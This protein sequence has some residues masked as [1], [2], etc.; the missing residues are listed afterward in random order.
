MSDLVK[1]FFNLSGYE[2]ISVDSRFNDIVSDFSSQSIALFL[3][4]NRENFSIFKSNKTFQDIIKEINLDVKNLDDLSVIINAIF[5]VK[6]I[7]HLN[8]LKTHFLRLNAAEIINDSYTRSLCELFNKQKNE[9]KVIKEIKLSGL[10]VE[11]NECYKNIIKIGIKDKTKQKLDSILQNIESKKFSIGV[12]GVMSAGKSTF[13]NALLGDEILGTST[14]P[15]T[16]NLTI[17]KHAQNKDDE[18]A[19]VY[20]WDKNEWEELKNIGKFDKKIESFIQE[21]EEKFKE[22]L[23]SILDSGFKEIEL[24]D[25]SE[26]TS[27]NTESKYC[28]L[29]KKV[30]LF[31]PLK[32]LENGVS[33]VDTPGLDDPVIKREEITKEYIKNC[34][35]LIHVMNA[36]CAATKVDI[37]FIT[38]SFLRH[39]IARMLVILTR[40]DLV[41]S[42]S[43]NA[44]MNYTKSEIINELKKA[45]FEGDVDS[46][47]D[48]IE[49]ISLAGYFA[50]LHKTNRA[51][52]ALDSGYTLEKTGI[53]EIENYLYKTLLG[54]DSAKN[55]DLLLIAFRGF[56]NEINSQINDLKLES[57]FLNADKTQLENLINDIKNENIELEKSLENIKIKN[58]ESKQNLEK[59]LE[60][61]SK[62]TANGIN[63]SISR[64]KDQIYNDCIYEYNKNSAPSSERI[65]QLVNIN[66]D[67]ISADILRDYK[68]KII[69]FSSTFLESNNLDFK[70]NTLLI[71]Q[72]LSLIKTN[73]STKIYQFIKSK[74]DKNKLDSGLDDIFKTELNSF[75]E[76][77]NA[78]NNNIKISLNK[79]IDSILKEQEKNI[80]S[81]IQNKKDNLQEILNKINS[82]NNTNLKDNIE[83]KINE[84]NKIKNELEIIVG[85]LQ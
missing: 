37:E 30:E 75:V 78:E 69:K 20:F 43:L 28:N 40:A 46:L 50:L 57:K 29:V 72:K 7:A 26:F 15:E 54:E 12:S 21:S 74:M 41:D 59:F 73:L 76:I 65:G 51:Q 68:Y 66:L 8:N 18:K 63:N 13:L 23:Y 60:N 31:T 38:E 33:I 79:I 2:Q 14:I 61:L 9:K 47:I 70:I 25:L 62:I 81:N 67:D 1:E 5:E 64:L 39:N 36:S 83:S 77:L 27:A 44:S 16:A 53:L 84:F 48:R 4:I 82:A 52:I 71:N 6:N 56:Y 10:K 55:K 34:D 49:F 58:A 22:N 85:A 11:L 45:E 80:E 24:K 35:L 19:I 17:L 3:S 32:F 42:N